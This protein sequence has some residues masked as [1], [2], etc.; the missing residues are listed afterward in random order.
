MKIKID[1]NIEWITLA[2]AFFQVM[3]TLA[4]AFLVFLGYIIVAQIIGVV[5]ICLIFTLITL[6]FFGLM[7]AG[8]FEKGNK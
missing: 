5:A 3:I 8:A 4:V 2:I 6:G 7:V 1:S